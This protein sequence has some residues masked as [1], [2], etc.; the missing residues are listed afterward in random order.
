MHIGNLIKEKLQE[1]GHSV[2]WFANQIC[3]TRT[4]VYKIFEKANIDTELLERIS[5]VLKYN[6]FKDISNDFEKQK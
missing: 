1:D 2:T 3:C 5:K 4:H 6:F